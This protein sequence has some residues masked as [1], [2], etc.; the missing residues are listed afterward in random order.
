VGSHWELWN[1]DWLERQLHALKTDATARS[2]PLMPVCLNE[3]DPPCSL[4]RGG[5]PA[6]KRCGD[7]VFL[8]LP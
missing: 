1:R 7:C 4:L 5:L 3:S 6:L 8:R 2:V